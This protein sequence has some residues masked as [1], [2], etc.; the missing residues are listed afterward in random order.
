[1]L[2]MALACADA[3]LRPRHRQTI[4]RKGQPSW[5]AVS[6]VIPYKTSIDLRVA[7]P[8]KD[9]EPESY[10]HVSVKQSA[11]EAICGEL[12]SLKQTS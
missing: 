12:C 11:E 2:A 3:W 5:D 4:H 10:P 7:A 8:I 6:T 1:M 9:T